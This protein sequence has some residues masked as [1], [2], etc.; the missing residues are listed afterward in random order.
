MRLWFSHPKIWLWLAPALIGA[1]SG[2]FA[3]LGFV[4]WQE[5]ATLALTAIAAFFG[6]MAARNQMARPQ[7]SIHLSTTQQSSSKMLGVQVR[8]GEAVIQPI[9][10][11]SG[12]GVAERYFVRF[13]FSPELEPTVRAECYQPPGGMIR[14]FAPDLRLYDENPGMLAGWVKTM[15]FPGA[16]LALDR[17][18]LKPVPGEHQVR[19]SVVFDH[20]THSGDAILKFVFDTPSE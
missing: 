2:I 7:L 20:G 4:T 3:R 10:R 12:D 8:D 6:W 1:G 11:N 9:L 19:Y 14:E 5:S 16:S 18:Y 15:I 13:S 17:I